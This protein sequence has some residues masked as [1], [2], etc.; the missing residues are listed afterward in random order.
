MP[1]ISTF[2]SASRRGFYGAGGGGGGGLYAFT[3]FTFLHGTWSRY[4]TSN[5]VSPRQTNLGSASVGDSR[6][7]FLGIYNTSTDPWLNDTAFYNVVTNGIQEWVCPET[8]VYTVTVAGACGGQQPENAVGAGAILTQNLTLTG[9]QTYR[10]LVGKKGENTDSAQNAGAGGGG[11]TFFF[12]NATDTLPIL[13]AGG[14]GG[15]CKQNV[16]VGA[17]LSTSGNNGNGGSVSGG[18][19]GGTSGGIPTVNSSDGNYDAGGGA[20]W[21]A[22]N[23]EINASADDGSFGFAP[24]NGGYGGFRSA[25]GSDDW[26]GHGGFGGGGGG[27]TENGNGG[28]GGGY[29]GGGKGSGDPTY[30]GGGG[31]GSYYSGTLVSS[32]VSNTGQGY[33]T[34]TRVA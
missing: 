15:S 14:G 22:G 33:V 28:G 26:G 2:G 4:P 29:S 6:A 31:G 30:G 18:A 10:I 3:S 13:V 12:I 34:I 7:T 24:R 5:G 21:L 8:G 11:G 16:G 23:G 9:S 19:V 17:S 25:D 32:S 20:G 1:F 27:T